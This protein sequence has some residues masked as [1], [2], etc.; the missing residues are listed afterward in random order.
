LPGSL[1]VTQ[2]VATNHE[3]SPIRNAMPPTSKN[4][5]PLKAKSI[6]RIV[7]ADD[8]ILLPDTI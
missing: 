4:P 7:I 2:I 8:L 3:I 5:H 1:R 6:D